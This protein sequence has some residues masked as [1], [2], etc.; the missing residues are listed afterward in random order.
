MAVAESQV[1]SWR[2]R[3][4]SGDG[5]SGGEG[6]N[7]LP[8]VEALPSDAGSNDSEM[9]IKWKQFKEEFEGQLDTSERAMERID[10][11]GFRQGLLLAATLGIA[12]Q[13]EQG[14]HV[15]V[16]SQSSNARQLATES[17]PLVVRDDSDVSPPPALDTS[18]QATPTSSRPS[19][20]GHHHHHH[21]HHGILHSSKY[22]R[23]SE[24]ELDLVLEAIEEESEHSREGS[25]SPAPINTTNT[26]TTIGSTTR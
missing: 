16:D 19:I 10:L 25:H 20:A 2:G 26:A 7:L 17:Q 13:R 24:V 3:V 22:E 23:I 21:V 8:A 4:C 6:G 5:G 9:D 12:E 1:L 18:P 15:T 14:D 11:E